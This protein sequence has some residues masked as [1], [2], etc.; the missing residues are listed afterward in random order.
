MRYQSRRFRYLMEESEQA[1]EDASHGP[2]GRRSR[3]AKQ[4]LSE[5][6]IHRLWE[7][8]HAEIVRPVAES[9]R[10][11]PQVLAL[12]HAEVQLLHRRA[13][14]DYIRC[15][16]VVGE[17]RDRLFAVFYGPR[18]TANAVLAE[19]RQYLLAVSSRVSTDHLINVM[20]D[21]QSIHLLR[22]YEA[23]YEE[24]FELYC[25]IATARDT[26]AADALKSTMLDARKTAMRIRKRLNSVLPSPGFSGFDRQVKLARSG[27]YPVLNYM[28][29]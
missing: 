8:R 6:R 4:V 18:E 17:P 3:I 26:L 13:L 14:I 19:H 27:R 23:A 1:L 9:S 2:R 25:F 22:L 21:R 29:G 15:N 12:R 5:P 20:H 11:S 24:Y 28:V 10:R 16:R 7:A